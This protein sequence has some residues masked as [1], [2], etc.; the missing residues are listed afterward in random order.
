MGNPYTTDAAT[1]LINVV[2][3]LYI[4]L[5]MLRFLFQW[6]RADFYNPVSQMVVK[7]TQP[8]LRQ[9]RRFIPGY[10]GVDLAALVLMLTLQL[11]ELW[12][13]FAVA[14]YAPHLGGLLVLAVAELMQ[15]AIY[16]FIIAIIVLVVISWVNPG[17]YNPMTGLLYS[18]T[19]PLLRPA[20]RLI[21][22]L[23]GLDISPVIVILAL[24]LA[25][26][27]IVR[28]IH[29]LARPLL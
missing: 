17:T 12:L 3:G 1:L 7:A 5:V 23:G 16:V 8:P 13:K 28:P 10:A 11:V 26:I 29:D 9:L 18:L 20:R 22:P 25:L 15:L 21:P 24:Q 19:A 27:L 14:G 4:L 6:V 2:F